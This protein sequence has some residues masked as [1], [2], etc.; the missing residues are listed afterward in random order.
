MKI[1]ILVA[2]FLISFLAS[3]STS[4]A[5]YDQI[6]VTA[7]RTPL[8]ISKIGSAITIIT[9]DEIE[10]RHARNLAD[11]LRSV[12]GFSVSQTGVT[13]AQ[14]Q[15]RV[16]GAEANHILVLID[17]IRANDPATGDEFRWE[18]LSTEN[19]ERI[20]IVRGPQSS[21]W[22][23]DAVAAVVHI[24]TRVKKTGSDFSAYAESGS[25]ATS[26]LGMNGA[27]GSAGWSL[28]GGVEH[29]ST[30]GS[31]ISRSGSENDD[32]ELTTA[33]LAARIEASDALS[34]HLRLRAV[35]AYTQYDP[36]DY[37]V[38]GLPVDG[39]VATDARHLYASIGGTMRSLDDRVTHRVNAHYFDSSNRNLVGGVYDSGTASTRITLS[40]QADI[41]IGKN[42]LSLAFEHEKTQ[43]EQRGAIIFG[44][45]NQDQEMAVT[46]V[47]AEYQGLSGERLSWILSARLDNNS[48][49][50][51][52]LNG[53]LSV[54]YQWSDD[55]TLR[56][57]VGTGQK[58][59]TFI[60]RF[61]YFPEQFIGNAALKPERSTSYDVGLDR[62]ILNG[63]MHLQIS[64]FRQDLVDE[65]NGFVF[66][67]A[68]FLSTAENLTSES[69]RS[70]MEIAVRWNL[71]ESLSLGGHYTNISATDQGS[72][73]VRRPR[74]SGGVSADF[75]SPN[76]R[77]T[78]TLNAD[79]GGTRSDIFFPPYPNP[80]EIVTLRNYW[81]L[82][83]ASQYQATPTVAV[84]VRGTNLLDEDYEQ[85]YGYRT[86]GRAGYL[87][88]RVSFG[89]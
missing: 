72:R 43:F 7:A 26:N 2:A 51:D 69:K 77:F 54:A 65:I 5:D 73:E 84:F 63:K 6:I 34:L 56:A 85:V 59:P 19:I 61:G 62:N 50:D 8:A 81:L 11:L 28:S 12:P 71:S 55:T 38:T 86:L 9:R 20:E 39:D 35:D 37:F 41:G 31:N 25:H 79:Y 40:Y 42:L 30:D 36:V 47:I 10:R 58:N 83:V 52:S 66:D 45:P 68:T 67:P 46:S 14:T 4:A 87:G 48:D 64:L 75:R 24:I 22:G 13:G 44:D 27:L 32:S 74:H 53:R 3:Q 1:S 88:V 33:T 15:I 29:L 57:G 80:P 89:R 70:G 78:T 82:D 16:R 23:S 76:E 17:G 21:L 18:Y 49:F 60:E